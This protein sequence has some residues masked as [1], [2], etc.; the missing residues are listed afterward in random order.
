LF[1]HYIFALSDTEPGETNLVEH[2]IDTSEE[3][4][5]KTTPRCLWYALRRELED[6]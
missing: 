5:V 4:P 2:I 3:K 1:K 6:E